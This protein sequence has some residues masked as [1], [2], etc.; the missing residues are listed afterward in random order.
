M[1]SGII[2]SSSGTDIAKLTRQ[3]RKLRGS[4]SCAWN[5]LPFPGV[6][7][8][9]GPFTVNFYIP[10]ISNVLFIAYFELNLIGIFV[11]HSFFYFFK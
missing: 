1:E 8:K 10:I 11:I 9:H 4:N 2:Q 6:C 5:R 3:L 7:P